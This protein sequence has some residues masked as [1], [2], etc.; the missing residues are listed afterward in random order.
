MRSCTGCCL[1]P[2]VRVSV[3]LCVRGVV[4]VIELHL[5]DRKLSGERCLLN[6]IFLLV[7]FQIHFVKNQTHLIST[8]TCNILFVQLLYVV[9][10][11]KTIK[12]PNV[13]SNI[14]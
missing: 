14:Q 4:T 2:C 6:S 9:F 1:C 7:S 13:W 12:L 8:A 11:K 5:A 10:Q 3:C